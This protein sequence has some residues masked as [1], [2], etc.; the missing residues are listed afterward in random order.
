MAFEHL[1][2]DHAARH[3]AQGD[4]DGAGNIAESI[5]LARP[6]DADA[7]HILGLVR[8]QHGQYSEAVALLQRS[9][10][11]V[12]RQPQVQLNLGKAL[13]AMGDS[14]GAAAALRA[15]V[16]LQPDSIDALFELGKLLHVT[17]QWE[18][19]EAAWRKALRLRPADPGL[20]LGLGRTL[21]AAG[22]SADAETVLARGVGEAQDP[23]L[24]AR[25]A[26][27]LAHARHRQGRKDEALAAMEIA[28]VA[29]PA[30]LGLKAKRA[31][32]LHDL[33]RFE[34]ALSS[35]REL[36]AK[37][38]LNPALHHDYNDLLYRLDIKDDYLKS[39]DRAPD[40]PH[41]ALGKAGFLMHGERYGEAEEVFAAL[42]KR[43]AD[44]R[45]A[46]AGLATAL[47]RQGRHDEA[48][49]LFEQLIARHPLDANLHAN[50]AAAR[51]VA[52]D[53]TRALALAEA[54]L[55]AQPGNQIC[56]AWKGTA[57]RLLDDERGEI[58]NGYDSL[59]RI[60]DLEPPEGFSN[61]ESFNR[62]LDAW[63]DRL[64]PT[65]REHIYQSLR[66]GSQT[67]EQIFGQGFELI[68]RLEKR[69]SEAVTRYV[70]DLKPDENHPF[71]SRKGEGF[72]YAGSWSSRLSDKGF[73]A[74]H[75][76]PEGW[77]S[78]CYY[79]AVPEAAKDENARQ[80]WIKFGEPDIA[81]PLKEPVRRAIQP[82]PGRL[83]LFPSYMWHGTIPFYDTEKRTT[84]AFDA[85]PR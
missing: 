81:V 27:E 2:A 6:S 45:H 50:A 28:T 12:P 56:L 20:K 18:E 79:V 47:S 34:E 70:A 22:K 73:H 8:A 69:I 63:L 65:T 57:L 51:A 64:H 40:A 15:A 67:V 85:V 39:Y 37:D 30:L 60:F 32:L 43:E 36:L 78:S 71:L 1:T 35:Y 11:S 29:M 19:A 62:E 9:L 72:S 17:G 83:V 75:L 55:A 54:G 82:K 49:S 77:I 38:P 24:K 53:A 48:A 25:L 84:I 31:E 66:G 80:G 59:V 13:G 61:M 58:L 7:L 3:L 41:L 23:N 76:H 42:L 5:L 74:N 46:G 52:G 16:K 14:D 10:Q 26:A 21:I 33:G 68:D 44:N 4:F